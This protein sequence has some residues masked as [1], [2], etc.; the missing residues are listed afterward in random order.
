MWSGIVEVCETHRCISASRKPLI[1]QKW[2]STIPALLKSPKYIT[3]GQ[4]LV[5]QEASCSF[6]CPPHEHDN[7]GMAKF[8]QNHHFLLE[9]G[10]KS[11]VTQACQIYHLYRCKRAILHLCLEH[12]AG[13][14]FSQL[15]GLV[16]IVGGG[17]QRLEGVLQAYMP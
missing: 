17:L 7:I 1:P 16:K 15:F 4:E 9:S 8:T 10:Y 6:S 11:I 14:S 3:T 5:Y 2:M 12:S 13:T